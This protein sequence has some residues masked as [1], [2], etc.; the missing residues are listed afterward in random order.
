[1]NDSRV[2][3]SVLLREP[4]GFER[5]RSIQEDLHMY[6]LSGTECVEPMHGKFDVHARVSRVPGGAN[7]GE[8]EVTYVKNL[9]WL[10]GDVLESL[11]KLGKCAEEA[12]GSSGRLRSRILGGQSK[13]AVLVDETRQVREVATVGTRERAMDPLHVLL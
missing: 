3:V 6:D 12:L 5:V 13:H 11:L 4:G 2:G 9:L 8:H 1:M 10:V 7:G